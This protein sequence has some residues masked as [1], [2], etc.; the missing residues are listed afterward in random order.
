M[1]EMSAADPASDIQMPASK[2]GTVS[3]GSPCGTSPTIATPRSSSP[4]AQTP[5]S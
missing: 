2:D 1:M 4:K 3:G 5:A